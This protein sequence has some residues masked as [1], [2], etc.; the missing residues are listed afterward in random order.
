MPVKAF[1]QMFCPNRLSRLEAQQIISRR[2]D[3]ANGRRVLYGLTD[4][5]K[6]L[7]P[8]MLAVIGWAEK[9]DPETR[10]SSELGGADTCRSV[11]G[12]R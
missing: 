2:R 8:V 6:D 10:I 7:L 3:P 4:K 12:P 9:Y 5:G 1:R 11:G